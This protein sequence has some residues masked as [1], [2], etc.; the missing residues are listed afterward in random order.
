MEVLLFP[1]TNVNLFPSTIKPLNVFE[2]R[3]ISM[4]HQA[5]SAKIPVAI[6]C[7]DDPHMVTAVSVGSQVPFVRE[8]AGYGSIEIVEKKI[9]GSLLCFIHGKGRVKLGKVLERGSGYLVVDAEVLPEV[10]HLS[11]HRYGDFA[12][13]T[14]ILV[15]WAHRNIPDPQQ[16]ELFISHLENPSD[17]VS[18]FATYILRDH[19]SQYHIL[20]EDRM[21]ERISLAYRILKSSE[22]LRTG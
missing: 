13:L 6:G 18:N 3:Y 2:Q 10:E 7:V 11:S 9:N 8:I 4:V 12:A 15:L 16:R 21:D 14:K 20:A 22:L 17:I 1:L 19:D 5:V